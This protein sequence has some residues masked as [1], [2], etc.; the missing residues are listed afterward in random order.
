MLVGWT[1]VVKAGKSVEPTADL[2]KMLVEK[3]AVWRE[4]RKVVLL[5]SH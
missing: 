4:W 3:M 2:E 5:D 1:V